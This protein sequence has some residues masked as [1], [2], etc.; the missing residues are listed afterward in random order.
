MRQRVPLGRLGAPQDVANAAVFL[1]SQEAGFISG[2]MLFVDGGATY[3]ILS[4]S[5]PCPT[6]MK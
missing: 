1:A 5:R 3:A 2:D 4:E 6:R